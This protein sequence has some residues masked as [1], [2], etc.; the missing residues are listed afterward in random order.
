MDS[1]LNTHQVDSNEAMGEAPDAQNT[2]APEEADKKKRK[3]FFLILFIV[4]LAG[5]AILTLILLNQCRPKSEAAA[6]YGQGMAKIDKAT[7]LSL[8]NVIKVEMTSAEHGLNKMTATLEVKLNRANNMLSM[9]SNNEFSDV[10]GDLMRRGGMESGSGA[11]AWYKD[12]WLYLLDHG[13]ET[14]VARDIP[15]DQVFSIYTS[16]RMMLDKSQILSEKVESVD[17]GKLITRVGNPDVVAKMSKS[18]LGTLASFADTGASFSE[19]V[20]TMRLDD[21]GKPTEFSTHIVGEFPE[22]GVMHHLVM[23]SVSSNISFEPVTFEFPPQEK[24]DAWPKDY[25]D[26]GKE[27]DA[28]A[29]PSKT[30]SAEEQKAMAVTL[31]PPGASIGMAQGGVFVIESDMSKAEIAEWFIANLPLLGAQE[32]TAGAYLPEDGQSTLL[33]RAYVKDGVGFVVM[34]DESGA[35]IGFT[36]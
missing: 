26:K 33:S 32:Q 4:L 24:L 16:G 5:M 18:L 22:N 10:E 8:T 9:Q 17:G 27:A 23:D 12:G 11:Q 25:Q 28:G 35:A 30:L 15:Q 29:K 31:L 14:G 1:E 20:L 13:G 6:A 19:L 21:K 2:P 34:V 3:K 36:Q 7:D